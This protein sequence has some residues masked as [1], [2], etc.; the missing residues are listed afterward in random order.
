M[1]KFNSSSV[2]SV[3]KINYDKTLLGS[4]VEDNTSLAKKINEKLRGMDSKVFIIPL[5]LN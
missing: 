2:L 1:I 3:M 5:S 4:I